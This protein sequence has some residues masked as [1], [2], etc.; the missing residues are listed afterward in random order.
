M[1]STSIKTTRAVTETLINL[2][3]QYADICHYLPCETVKTAKTVKQMRCSLKAVQE[4]LIEWARVTLLLEVLQN[5]LSF[6]E[7][8]KV[9][10]SLFLVIQR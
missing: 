5:R 9:M 10:M 4:P 1:R 3:L 2:R 6:D 7:S 8:E